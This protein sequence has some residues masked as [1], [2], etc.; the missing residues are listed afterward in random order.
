MKIQTVTGSVSSATLRLVDGHG[1]VWIKPP[2]GVAPEACFELDDY[3]VI[4]AE[5]KDFRA[6]G[7][8]M[9]VDCQPGGCGRDG[10]MLA[11]LAK[12][13]GI[14]ITATTGFH[15]QIYYP[16]SSWLWSSS[17]EEAAAYFVQEL[18]VGMQEASAIPATTIKVGYE[19]A[20]TEQSRVLMEAAAEA[21]HQTGALIIFHTESGRNVE[22]L[23]PFF[24]DRGV[25]PDRLYL[26]HMDK[27]P[28]IGLHRELARAGVLL[29]YDTFMRS[30]Y[31]PDENLWPLLRQMVEEGLAE[32]ITIGLDMAIVSTWRRQG[33]Q[34]SM[35]ALP[36][37][38]I[39]RLRAEGMN[40]SIIALL[41]GQNIISRL[42]WQT[43]AH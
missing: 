3:P 33:G 16:A 32:H 9:I 38:I 24:A 22:I 11:R 34:Q 36:E 18:T 12:A 42:A 21:A 13:T 15:R 8:T 4:A 29:G 25:A 23:L 39:P 14:H 31:N 2:E 10:R 20:I 17:A 40:E 43:P 1:H 19:G 27:R 26:C 5:L 28:D 30:T 7:G 41:A 6:A 37:Q 35:L